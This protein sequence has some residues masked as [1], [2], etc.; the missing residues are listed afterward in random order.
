MKFHSVP[1][2]QAV[3]HVLGHNIVNKSGRRI[4]RKGRSLTEADAALLDQEGQSH[5]YVAELGADD[6]GEN[7][8][9]SQIVNAFVGDNVTISNAITG[10][11]NIYA[12]CFGVLK[13]NE[14][15]LLA[16]NMIDG[17][18]MATVENYEVVQKGDI[19]ANLKI[20][21]YALSSKTVAEA[22]ALV[23][24][25]P[26]LELMPLLSRRIGF[27]ITGSPATEEKSVNSFQK[28]MTARV[29]PLNSE[30]TQTEFVA[31]D[32]TYV[33][34][35]LHTK[36]LELLPAHDMVLLA[37]G[38]AI[39]DRNDVVPK[40]IEAA[41]GE[42]ICFGAPVEP[43]NLFLLAYLD[44]KPIVG[45]PGCARSPITNLVD[46]ILPRLLAGERLSRKD[47]ARLGCG[48]LLKG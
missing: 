17:L 32:T 20:L 10:R 33:P 37:S 3:G 7:E 27:I 44:H 38:T 2:S 47:I 26:P 4:L 42:V 19:I 23:Q 8:A 24:S 35:N 29:E 41:G 46:L 21:P 13:V 45:I 12:N 36:I 39:M 15:S 34:E 11:V 14:D 16:L 6:I 48:G 22:T 31:H 9:S 28:A 30:I 43:G 40:A 5:V 18:G 25:E 1:I